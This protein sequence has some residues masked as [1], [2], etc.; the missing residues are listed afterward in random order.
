M[1]VFNHKI[2][3]RIISSN[4]PKEIL[5]P[6][7]KFNFVNDKKLDYS[8]P[9]FSK[10]KDTI[11]YYINFGKSRIEE[12]RHFNSDEIY[13]QQLN[14]EINSSTPLEYIPQ[15]LY[16]EYTNLIPIFSQFDEPLWFSLCTV[17]NKMQLSSDSDDFI[18][19]FINLYKF[20]INKEIKSNK[21]INIRLID[22]IPN[23]LELILSDW[24]SSEF[25]IALNDNEIKKNSLLCEITTIVRKQEKNVLY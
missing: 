15:C 1:E 24:E 25:T 6:C 16:S 4:F 19:E 12:S 9:I 17:Y 3:K 5:F 18:L 2:N 20:I 10:Y 13:Q 22:K 11:E 8:F 21:T 14:I 7:T 23:I